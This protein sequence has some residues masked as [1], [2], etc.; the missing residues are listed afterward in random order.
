[1]QTFTIHNDLDP[2][3]KT[4]VKGWHDGAGLFFFPRSRRIAAPVVSSIGTVSDTV[5]NFVVVLLTEIRAP[6]QERPG[7]VGTKS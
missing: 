1:M 6:F 7:H 4:P 3:Q 2:R 5:K